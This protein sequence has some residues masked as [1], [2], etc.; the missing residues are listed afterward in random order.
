MSFEDL[1]D[2][3]ILSIFE[4]LETSKD[5]L[6]LNETCI[7]FRVLNK[8]YGYLRTVKWT[9]NSDPIEM[10]QLISKH[11]RT[12][13]YLFVSAW[14]DVNT[15][16][17]YWPEKV[18]LFRTFITSP[19]APPKNVTKKLKVIEY[20]TNIQIEWDKLPHLEELR[21]D[22][23]QSLDTTG[24]EKCTKLRVI[25]IQQ[26]KPKQLNPKICQLPNLEKLIS[27]QSLP[28]FD[29]KSTIIF[30]VLTPNYHRKKRRITLTDRN[31]V[32]ASCYM[33]I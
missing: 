32:N 14:L 1:P 7:R 11:K 12:L 27:N 25:I 30:S 20:R 24:I 16:V 2:D 26:S 33:S 15:W 8:S 9:N 18:T 4:Y 28:V 6:V 19:I 29:F 13:K 21:V 23:A 22:D 3:M 10:I 17:Y 31:Y 5:I